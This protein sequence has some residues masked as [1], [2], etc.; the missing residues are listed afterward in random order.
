ML[1]KYRVTVN[2]AITGIVNVSTSPLSIMVQ[3]ALL[4]KGY[5][6]ELYD[7]VSTPPVWVDLTNMEEENA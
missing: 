4:E 1:S 3:G 7:D 6:V 2:E 5:K